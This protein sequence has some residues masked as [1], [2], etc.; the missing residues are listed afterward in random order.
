[1]TIPKRRFT[2][3]L[4]IKLVCSFFVASFILTAGL[5]S[6]ISNSFE[7]QSYLSTHPYMSKQFTRIQKEL[8]SPPNIH[9]AKQITQKFPIEIVINS[10]HSNW[11]S[12]GR[13]IDNSVFDVNYQHLDGD[14]IISEAGL[15]NG[16]VLFRTFHKDYTVSFIMTGE[17]KN[18]PQWTKLSLILITA[19]LILGL[20][21]L[22]IG[23]LFSPVHEIEK[24]VKRIGSGDFTHRLPTNY[25]G[26]WGTLSETIN[27][28]ANNIEQILLAKRQLLLAISHELR[29]PITRSKIALSLL[30]DSPDK[31]SIAEDILEMESLINELLESER[32]RENYSPL[33]KNHV[34]VNEIIYQVSG[35]FFETRPLTF[36][37][38]ETLPKTD[39]DASR[40]GLVIKNLITNAL[41]A[42]HKDQPV[43]IKTSKNA[44]DIIISVHDSGVGIQKDHI[45]YITEPF[46]R[47]DSS[48][49]R[50]TGGT[51]V[52]LYLIKI[53]VEAHNGNLHIESELN[54]GTTVLV[55][56]PIKN[57]LS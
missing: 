35:R 23:H 27:K 46:Y 13:F 40:I 7:E 43:L 4:S 5:C 1:M 21:F 22:I 37:L 10:P 25:H 18:T 14:K 19:L 56:L 3:K 29:T 48:R 8:G 30:E 6:I 2:T 12:N 26:E 34:H 41:T 49:Q 44:T 9:A 28:M 54:K 16:N 39:L 11:S 53:I 17:L 38:D 31:A 42:S 47:T 51:G 33:R 32:L 20:L 52:G 24:G 55:S 45:P 36:E 15:Y 50:R 57:E